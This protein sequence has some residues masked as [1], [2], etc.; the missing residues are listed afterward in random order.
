LGVADPVVDAD[1]DADADENGL[2]SDSLFLAALLPTTPPTTAPTITST[3][4]T[5][6]TFRYWQRRR[7]LIGFVLV[8][9]SWTDIAVR[10]NLKARML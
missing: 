4:M 9:R 1:A 7:R 3:R 2:L 10:N 5:P 8:V 6:P